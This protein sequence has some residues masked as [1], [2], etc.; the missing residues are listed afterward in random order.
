MAQNNKK[1]NINIV[2]IIAAIVVFILLPNFVSGYYVRI[3]TAIFMY[4]TIAQCINLMSGYMGYLPF[5][6]VMFFGIGAY[7][8]AILMGRGLPFIVA[9]P[10]ASVSA[11]VVSIILGFPVL[12]LRGHYFA[13]AT[14]GMN[15]A[16]MS[17]A[18]NA[19]EITGGAMG[20]TYP[21]IL[22][23]PGRVYNYFYL[24]FLGLMVIT[25]LTMYFIVNSKFGYGIR[26][27]KANE[28]AA[29]SMGINT[30]YT[31][32]S[33]WAISALFTS[34]AG[35]LYGY[36]M[37]FISPDEVFDLMFVTNSIIM[38]LIGGAGT[39]LGPIVGAFI[40]ESV[41]EFAWSGFMEYHLAVLGIATIVIVFFVPR[42]V[43]GTI[44][45]K[46]QNR[47]IAMS[48]KVEVTNG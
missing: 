33:A 46:I 10:L 44:T 35:G 47:K 5:G 6:H 15:G 41:S 36:W 48:K 28:E 20:T 32:V 42:G 27:I 17:V 19:T 23:P 3:F 21:I 2:F 37:S 40:I 8:T 18:Q 7:M 16:I 1:F 13:I 14:I 45:D 38:M 31:K 29:N 34:I 30:T 25:A 4:A 9:I 24:A 26:S 43:I 12:R 39:I 22:L 11:I